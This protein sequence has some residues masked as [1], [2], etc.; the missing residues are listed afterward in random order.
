MFAAAPMAYASLPSIVGSTRRADPSA[1]VAPVR[2]TWS[3]PSPLTD[4]IIDAHLRYWRVIV[5]DAKAGHPTAELRARAMA[6]GQAIYDDIAAPRGAEGEAAWDD[7][8]ERL[9][10]VVDVMR[11]HL[12]VDAA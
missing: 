9:E 4:A 6:R 5:D 10:Y 11:R 8:R 7:A 2:R 3:V 12:G 1:P